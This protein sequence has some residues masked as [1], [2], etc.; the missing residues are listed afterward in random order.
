MSVWIYAEQEWDFA[1]VSVMRV[2]CEGSLQ[3]INLDFGQN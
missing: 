1:S 2:R 3:Y